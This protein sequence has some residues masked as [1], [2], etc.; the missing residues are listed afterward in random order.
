[1]L[2]RTEAYRDIIQ[3]KDLPIIRMIPLDYGEILLQ[4]IFGSIG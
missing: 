2:F 1:M 4:A 3:H